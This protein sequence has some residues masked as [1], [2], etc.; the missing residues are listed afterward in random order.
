MRWR[1]PI[2]VGSL[3]LLLCIATIAVISIT[4]I[5]KRIVWYLSNLQVQIHRWLEPPESVVFIPESQDVQNEINEIVRAT[6]TAVAPRLSATNTV[7]LP[8]ATPTTI[9]FSSQETE[10]SY[11]TETPAPAPTS[12]PEKVVL[13]GIRFE[14]QQFNNCGPANLAMLLSYWGWKGDQRDT[15]AYLRPNL[16][17]DDKNVNPSE[18]VAFVETQTQLKAVSRVGGTVGLLKQLIA[19]GFPVLIEKGHDPP[20]DWWMGHYALLKRGL[21]GF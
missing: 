5:H 15:R 10:Q 6:L 3:I 13:K 7:A 2:F 11:P 14:Y 17:V 1:I 19:A 16:N 20:D 4:D 8:T 18:M 21:A 9:V 12:L